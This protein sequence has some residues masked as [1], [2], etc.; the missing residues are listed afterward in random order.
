MR[1][2]LSTNEKRCFTTT[3][4]VLGYIFIFYS[5]LTMHDKSIDLLK[6]Y[7]LRAVLFQNL[8]SEI[9]HA[10]EHAH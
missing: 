10:L 3:S 7:A 5:F 6:H 9:M 1:P 4:V 2:K 8:A